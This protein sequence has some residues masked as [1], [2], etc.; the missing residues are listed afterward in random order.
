MIHAERHFQCKRKDEGLYDDFV[1][2]L[3]TNLN[4]NIKLEDSRNQDQKI[5][6]FK[7][8]TINKM[9]FKLKMNS[10]LISMTSFEFLDIYEQFEEIEFYEMMCESADEKSSEVGT[11]C[12]EKSG[13]SMEFDENSI[14]G[15]DRD[16]DCNSAIR[17]SCFNGDV[18]DDKKFGFE[19]CHHD[20]L[21][22]EYERNSYQDDETINYDINMEINDSLNI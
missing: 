10:T 11:N 5:D 9:D 4:V 14:S 21:N 16:D 6:E 18:S 7:P 8:P 1:I 17:I 15:L 22:S 2:G 20:Q 19:S 13:F 3:N 12:A